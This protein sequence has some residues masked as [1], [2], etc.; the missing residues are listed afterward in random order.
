MTEVLG[1]RREVTAV[2]VEELW[3]GRRWRRRVASSFPRRREPR[4]SG[5]EKRPARGRFL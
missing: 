2:V 3:P 4:G 1:K 5:N